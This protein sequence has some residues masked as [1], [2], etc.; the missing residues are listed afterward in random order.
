MLVGRVD[1]VFGYD[2]AAHLQAGDI[3]VKLA[4]H[5][6]P[7]KTTGGPQFAGNQAAM[8]SQRRQDAV[9]YRPFC[10]YWMS[11]AAVVIEVGPPLAADESGFLVEELAVYA[12]AIGDDG[13]F[14]FL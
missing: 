11:A 13:A 12:V 10:R 8:L 14:P 2:V 7:V 6:R 4:A 5:L 9:F 3:A 1:E